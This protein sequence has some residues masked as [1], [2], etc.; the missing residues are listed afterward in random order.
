[1]MIFRASVAFNLGFMMN[2]FKSI[3]HRLC[4]A[5]FVGVFQVSAFAGQGDANANCNSNQ[6]IQKFL[7]Y[8]QAVANG[9]NTVEY[10][11]LSH[12]AGYMKLPPDDENVLLRRRRE[13]EMMRNIHEHITLGAV[14]IRIIC[15]KPYS[16]ESVDGVFVF[17][18]V[19]STLPV[20]EP[21][22]QF[23]VFNGTVSSGIK[24]LWVGISADG[25]TNMSL[26]K[27]LP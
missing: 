14:P 7:A 17:E 16:K 11:S 13:A 20:V 15:S 24:Y 9:A 2:M 5:L 19:K 27:Q 3:W 18:I 4:L 8:R 6:M 10:F 22:K 23:E 25:I 21:T 12:V 1:M 26:E